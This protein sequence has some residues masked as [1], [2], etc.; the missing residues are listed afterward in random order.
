MD[1]ALASA[2]RG[3][4]VTVEYRVEAD[5]DEV[6]VCER[7]RPRAGDGGSPVIVDGILEDVSGRRELERQLLLADAEHAIVGR[8]ARLVAEGPPLRLLAQRVAEE[9][10]AW[11]G[12]DEAVLWRYREGGARC[13]G[14]GWAPDARR[15]LKPG[16]A[17]VLDGDSILTRILAT[18]TQAR[19]DD[20]GSDGSPVASFLKR[21][22]RRSA[23]GAP[24]RVDG[25]TW[26][27]LVVASD[28]VDALGRDAE[29]RLGRLTELVE[30]AIANAD[31]REQL[32][33]Q[34]DTDALTGIANRRSFERALA[35]EVERS[36]ATRR[37]LSFVLLDLDHFKRFNDTY[38]HMAGDAALIQ[39]ARLMTTRP[40]RARPWRAWVARS[41]PGCCRA[42]PSS[43][44]WTPSSACAASSRRSRSTASGLVTLSAG[45]T[46]LVEGG[47]ALELY[48]YA[49][50]A[51]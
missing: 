35:A 49:D 3:E 43:R 16:D 44:R 7:L 36:L 10:A 15:A 38:G 19:I 12:C 30:L 46:Q 8:V 50:I 26:G 34:A 48:S 4:A 47:T 14:V 6:W 21:T 20:V 11:V 33:R 32:A 51:L 23:V 17:V 40:A 22:A 27:A 24:V 13:L 2:A 25:A 18:G 45:I 37:P 28:P 41:S 1:E 39:V 29:L 31:A 5:G 42:P 9:A